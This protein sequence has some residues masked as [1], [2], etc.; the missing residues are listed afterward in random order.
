MRSGSSPMRWR[1]AAYHRGH[2][3]AICRVG[4]AGAEVAGRDIPEAVA[5][6]DH[7]DLWGGRGRPGGAG[8]RAKTMQ[9]P[10]RG[11]GRVR[12]DRGC[13]RRRLGQPTEA[14]DPTVPTCEPSLGGAGGHCQDGPRSGSGRSRLP[15]RS[16][17][18]FVAVAVTP[19]PE[20]RRRRRRPRRWPARWRVRRRDNSDQAA[21]RSGRWR[22]RVGPPGPRRVREPSRPWWREPPR[23][24]RGGRRH[25]GRR[26]PRRAGREG[27]RGRRSA[28]TATPTRQVVRTT[29]GSCRRGPWC[30]RRRSRTGPGRPGP[31]W[32]SVAPSDDGV[33]F[34]L[35]SDDGC[36]KRSVP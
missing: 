26:W 19:G 32:S 22:W 15:V 21:Q 35:R 10:G 20:D 2:S 17:G 5:G 36:V 14:S 25:R 28:A 18:A 23:P 9:G 31:A 16:V 29:R 12:D 1:L 8:E 27:T 3:A 13:G 4:R 30:R 24:A 11:G 6:H 33:C 7:N 34:S